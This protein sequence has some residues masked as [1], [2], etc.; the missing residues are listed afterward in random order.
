MSPTGSEVEP[1]ELLS[2]PAVRRLVGELRGHQGKVLPHPEPQ[3]GFGDAAVVRVDG[4][5][6]GHL[7]GYQSDRKHTSTNGGLQPG[8]KGHG[9]T[10]A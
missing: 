7:P 3:V 2:S 5:D 4:V 8:Q 10:A 6:A 1:T 9:C